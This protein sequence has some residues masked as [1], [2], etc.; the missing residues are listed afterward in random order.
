MGNGTRAANIY[1]LL[2]HSLIHL[3]TLSPHF[4]TG[5]RFRKASD[6]TVE[7]LLRRVYFLQLRGVSRIRQ[8]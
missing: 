6:R 5:G 4:P 7:C 2:T 1:Y 3:L 8:N